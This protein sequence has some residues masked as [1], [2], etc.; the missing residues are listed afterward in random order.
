MRLRRLGKGTPLGATLAAVVAV[1]LCSGIPEASARRAFEAG[2]SVT[3][4]AVGDILLDRGVRRQLDLHG[5]LYP[6]RGVRRELRNA[7]IAVGNL[8]CPIT[9]RGVPAP[10]PISFRASPRLAAG[11]SDAGFDILSLANNHTLDR[12]RLGLTDTL[13]H[14]N[15]MGI[16]ACGAGSTA[17]EAASPVVIS[18]SGVRMAF[19]GFCDVVQDA[20]YAR[21]DLPTVADASPD[22]VRAA[23]KN[24]SRMADVVVVSMHWGCEYQPRPT[25]RQRRLAHAAA[26]AGADLILG[27]HPHVLQGLEWM[28]APSGRAALVAY[29]LGNFVFDRE[30][31]GADLS[32][33]LRVTVTR[34][35]VR[36]AEAKPCIIRACAPTPASDGP[37]QSILRRLQQLS[38]EMGTG[39]SDGRT[40]APPAKPTP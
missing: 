37:R 30:R 7:D 14:L 18:R 31:D 9:S 2:Q 20:S 29:S 33:I 13:R 4:A 35:G 22:A 11:L 25:D 32:M 12:G 39:M 26:S 1:G 40:K 3:I 36:R 8:E 15:A 17:E 23:V 19:V 27:H 24:A 38:Q 21:K 34:R 16:A 28:P 6:F 5:A 10:K